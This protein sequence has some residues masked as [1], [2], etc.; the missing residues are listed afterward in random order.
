MKHLSSQD[1]DKLGSLMDLLIAAEAQDPLNDNILFSQALLHERLGSS[2]QAIEKLKK[3]VML[4]DKHC[5]GWTNLGNQWF[6]TNDFITAGKFYQQA[7]ECLPIYDVYNRV[8][9]QSNIGQSYRERGQLSQAYQS[10]FSALA[11][12]HTTAQH[13]SMINSIGIDDHENNI[14]SEQALRYGAI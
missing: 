12:L 2:S 13:S 7:L 9:L 11:I 14:V 3:V 6:K 10:F 4:N 1:Q 8:L 5:L